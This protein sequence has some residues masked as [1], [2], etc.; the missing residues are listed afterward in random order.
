MKRVLTLLI[1]VLVVASMVLVAC[2]PEAAPPP[3]EEEEAPPEEE[4]EEAPPAA[5]EAEVFEVTWQDVDPPGQSQWYALQNLADRVREASGGRLDITVYSEGEVVPRND[6]TPAVKDGVVDIA[7]IATAMDQGRIGPA[8]YLL[9]SSGLPAGPS[10]IECIAWLYKGGGLDLLNEVYEDWCYVIGAS[11]GAAELFCHSNEPLDTAAAFKGVKFRTMGMWAEVLGEYGASVTMIPGA[12][13][14]SSV[15]RGV[16]DAFEYGPPST[17][18]VQ[19][20]HE[21]CEYVG[22]PGIQSPGYTK[23]VLVN[24][25]F[26]DGLPDDLQALLSHECMNLSLDSYCIVSYEDSLAMQ[27][28][29]D[30]GTKFF[31]VEEDFQADIA[32]KSKALCE[33]YAAEDALFG[34]VWDNQ[35]EFFSVWRSLSGIFPAYTLYD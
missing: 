6:A 15:E 21:V 30:Y 26:F 20:F 10:T 19:G 27:K 17:N 29:A 1:S 33:K 3:E 32:A 13:L 2:A 31:T 22:L 14:Y 35:N 16:I 23:P 28:Y 5:P 25:E 11:A 4:E 9:T 8:T 34:K 7:T 24:K 18:W 12:E